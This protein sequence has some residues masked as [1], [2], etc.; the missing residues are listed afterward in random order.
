MARTVIQLFG[1]N[2]WILY[3]PYEAAVLVLSFL[4]VRIVRLWAESRVSSRLLSIQVENLLPLA[5]FV[6][7]VNNFYQIVAHF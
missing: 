3:L 7:L 1:G 5:I 2:W 4:V 6:T